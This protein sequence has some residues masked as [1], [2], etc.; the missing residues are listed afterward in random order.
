MLILRILAALTIF[1]LLMVPT[2]YYQG[3]RVEAYLAPVIDIEA[4]EVRFGKLNFEGVTRNVMY[5]R[6]HTNKYRPPCRL[7]V[8]SFRWLLDHN[9]AVTPVYV[10]DDN[11]PFQPQSIVTEGEHTS[12]VLWTFIPY[13]AYNYPTAIFRGTA[14][15]AC[16]GLW[17]LPFSFEIV[18]DTKTQLRELRFSQLQRDVNREIVLKKIEEW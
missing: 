4:M 6:T 14:Y 10:N 18:I 5:F 1:L 3:P 17:P 2:F 13:E 8:F 7:D 16:H 9:V 11:L 15:F 12:R